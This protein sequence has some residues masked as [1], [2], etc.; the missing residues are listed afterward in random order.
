MFV[1]LLNLPALQLRLRNVSESY[2]A[3]SVTFILTYFF[4]NIHH[5]LAKIR[6]KGFVGAG[7]PLNKVNSKK[8]G[9]ASE[10]VSH[11]AMFVFFSTGI[12]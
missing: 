12:V 10:H 9:P 1:V 6:F 3:S 5:F 11:Y 7:I 2:S 8:T 4:F